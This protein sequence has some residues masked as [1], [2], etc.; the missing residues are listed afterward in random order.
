MQTMAISYLLVFV[1]VGCLPADDT[2]FPIANPADVGIDLAALERLKVRAGQ[3]DSDAVVIVKDG[4][5]VADWTFD[6]AAGPIEAMSMTKSVVNLA[7]GRLIDAGL[8]ASL[9]QPVA[10]FYPEWKQGRKQLITIRH[11]LNHTSGLDSGRFT[12]EIYDSPDVVQYALAAELSDDPGTRF[13]YNNKAVNLLAGIVR[14]ASGR[15]MDLYIGEEIFRPMGITDFT[16]TLDDAGNPYAMAGLHLRAIDLAKIGQ[17]MLDGGTWRE[18]RVV[19]ENWV[20]LSTVQPGQPH[21]PTSGLLW[22]LICE[23][24]SYEIDD[25]MI[26]DLKEQGLTE[27][28]LKKIEPLKG[29]AMD[30]EG[31]WAALR[32]I[33]FE[34]PVV[35]RKLQQLDDRLR[36]TG[37]PRPRPV[38]AGPIEGFD[39]QGDRGQYLLV[40]P[41]TRI[42][43][44]RQIRAP[45]DQSVKTDDFG[46]FLR[47][48][49]DLAPSDLQK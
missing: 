2:T 6:K 25:A 8:I 31:V 49:Q 9:D 3:A 16:W 48:V 22:W 38:S 47:M 4:K 34:D 14:K 37:R 12:R 33:L 20:R 18:T 7:V 39:A 36:V 10:D 24:V 41:K 28:S 29:K 21:N 23:T 46:E 35:S 27:K 43:A 5:L 40:L 44:V 45:L 17:M 42:V 26:A 19:S 15:R 30:M 13:F 32:P 11:L 1:V